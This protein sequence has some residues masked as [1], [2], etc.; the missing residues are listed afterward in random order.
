MP[1]VSAYLGRNTASFVTPYANTIGLNGSWNFFSPDPAHTMYVRY[2]ISFADQSGEQV[3]DPIEGYFPEEKNQGIR[4]DFHKRELYAMRFMVIDPRRL[5]ILY[6][7][8]LCK[9]F[10]GATSVQME[11][12]VET[13]PP[14]DQVVTLKEEAV[15]DLSQEIQYSNATYS[16]VT[17]GDEEVL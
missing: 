1:N 13:V 3:K 7:P 17:G 8:W 2:V 9:R 11:H 5:R 10:P 14:L 4:S 15:Q 16:C 6:G 12:I